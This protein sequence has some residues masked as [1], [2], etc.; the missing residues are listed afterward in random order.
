MTLLIFFAL[1]LTTIVLSILI[2]R[3]VK[4][5]LL[6]A[7]S[8]FSVVLLVAVILANT[9]LVVVAILLGILSFLSAFLDCIFM[10]TCFWR[11]NECLKCNNPYN[12][13]SDNNL[14]P[15][16]SDN[17]NIATNNTNSCGCGNRYYR[18]R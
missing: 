18:R 6:V 17:C 12:S 14:I 11:N 2:N 1:A 7:L 16:A 15:E 9:T 5:P 8:V 4:C 3:L 13:N 10:T